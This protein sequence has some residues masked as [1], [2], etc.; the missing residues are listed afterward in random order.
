MKV[1][2]FISKTAQRAS[3]EVSGGEPRNLEVLTVTVLSQCC[4]R[5]FGFGF[6]PWV[7]M[8]RGGSGDFGAASHVEVTS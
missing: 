4:L 5:G 2:Y 7:A 1:Y 3:A 6:V 8:S